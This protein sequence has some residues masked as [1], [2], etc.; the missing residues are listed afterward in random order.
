[1]RKI[2]MRVRFQYA[3]Y[4]KKD[5]GYCVFNYKAETGKTIT[6]IGYYLP[7][8]KLYYEFELKEN[9][10]PNYGTQYKVISFEESKVTTQEEI[11][12]YISI[13]YKGIGKKLA[14]KIYSS[15]GE[16]SIDIIENTPEQLLSI[17]GF[18]KK[19]IER[20]Q[21][22][23][24][25]KNVN[26]DIYLF[27]LS[28]HF[29]QKQIEKII[30]LF[31]ENILEQIKSNPYILCDI[32]GIDFKRADAL[33]EICQIETYDSRRMVAACE[34]A[35]KDGM[36]KGH[37]GLTQEEMILSVYKLL[38]PEKA[39]SVCRQFIWGQ[40]RNFVSQKYFSYRKVL[41]NNNIVFLLYL[42]FIQTAENQLA[43]NIIKFLEI[44]PKK[45]ENI[46]ILIKYHSSIHNLELDESQ[47]DALK[48]IMENQIII[49]TGGPGTGKTSI[50]K[51]VVSMYKELYKDEEIIFLAPTGRAARRL[52]ES[53]ED[54]TH[55]IHS[56][57]SLR[58]KEQIDST[59]EEN[60]ETITSGFVIVDEFSLVDML[61]AHKLF[62]NTNRNVKILLSGDEDQLAS[63]GPGNVLGDMIASG[64]IPVARLKYSHRQ[65]KGS[66]IDKNAKLMREGKTELLENEDFQIIDLSQEQDSSMLARDN[67]AFLEYLEPKIVEDFLTLYQDPQYQ[68]IACLCPYKKYPCGVYS[69][70][71]KIQEIVNP[72]Q[73]RLQ[74]HGTNGMVFR[75]KDW[76]MHLKN[77]DDAMNGDIGIVKRIEK[78]N[79]LGFRLIA[80]YDTYEGLK[81]IVYTPDD[82]EQITLAYAITIHKSQGSEY[83]AVITCFTDFHKQM[84]YRNVLYTDITR[85]KKLVKIYSSKNLLAKIINNK[86]KVMR[87]TLLAYNLQKE[88]ESRMTQMHLAL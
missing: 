57:F 80:E 44:T 53:V 30:N 11:I 34:Q 63:V 20:I 24:E 33:K 71:Q 70:N 86:D 66:L 6:C 19:K 26:R 55:T 84:L 56:H 2:D 7:K 42:N 50:I 46:D 29:S 21:T 72:Q 25:K 49:L 88:Y 38:Q 18:T 22:F 87:H 32:K 23:C 27:L 31:K 8:D 37:I 43:D 41:F 40:I 85:A 16:Q 35:L 52:S 3:I 78:H 47:W 15:F 28:Y 61:L 68:T 45:V 81:E 77:E 76:I 14:E 83:D 36:L 75:E 60:V 69:M 64:V 9:K 39:Y 13:S 59:Y 79:T 73:G 54:E 48:K 12:E 67:L 58:I 62:S 65:G 17:K 82:M 74:M 5:N 1:M 51:L 10:H 4:E